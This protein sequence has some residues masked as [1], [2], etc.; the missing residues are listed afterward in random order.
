[1]RFGSTNML[2]CGAERVKEKIKNLGNITINLVFDS[3][4]SKTHKLIV[5]FE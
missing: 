5:C 2:Y 4:A 3:F 1:M